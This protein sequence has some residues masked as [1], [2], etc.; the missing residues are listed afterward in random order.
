MIKGIIRFI[1]G[2]VLVCVIF[3][4]LTLF[5]VYEILKQF[6]VFEFQT[7]QNKVVDVITDTRKLFK[8]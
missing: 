2:I 6:G 7:Q 8:T 5:V 1:S 4:I 3:F